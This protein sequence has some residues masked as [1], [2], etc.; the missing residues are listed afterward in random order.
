MHRFSDKLQLNVVNGPSLTIP[1]SACGRGTTLVTEPPIGSVLDLGPQFS[2]TVCRRT[3][4]LRNSGRRH[5]TITWSTEGFPVT[6]KSSSWRYNVTQEVKAGKA[7]KSK[8]DNLHELNVFLKH[9][10]ALVLLF[11]ELLFE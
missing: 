11:W 5:Q 6:S 8:V 4:L 9:C 1:L 3:F 7:G 2:Q 10:N